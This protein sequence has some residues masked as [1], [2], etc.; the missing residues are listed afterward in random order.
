MSPNDDPHSCKNTQVLNT[1]KTSNN[2]GNGV[3]DVG[4]PGQ[5]VSHLTIKC[6]GYTTT[7]HKRV[8]PLLYQSVSRVGGRVDEE[9]KLIRLVPSLMVKVMGDKPEK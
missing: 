9:I 7:V 5:K 3:G 1:L 2:T 4:V 6:K 8:K